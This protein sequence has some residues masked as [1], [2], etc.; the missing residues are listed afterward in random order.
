MVVA[1]PAPALVGILNLPDDSFAGDGLG[2]N[3]DAA[4]SRAEAMLRE[5]A[6]WLDVGAESSR[7]GATAVDEVTERNRVAAICAALVARFDAQV[8]VDTRRAT[9]AEAALAA[10]ARMVNDTSG[11]PT[12]AMAAVV[13]QAGA[14]WVLMHAPHDL[15]DMAPSQASPTMPAGAAAG[16]ARIA[17]DLRRMREEALAAGVAAS[18]L[19][20][21]PGI[22][23]GKDVA[24]N[25]A[26]LLPQPALL[27]L[28]MPLYLGPSRK[29]VLGAVTGRRVE[30]RLPATAVAVAAAVSAG[31][32]YLR[33]HD[34]AAAADAVAM[35][36]ALMEVASE[37][38]LRA[39]AGDG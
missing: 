23:F 9:T 14:A 25:L 30:D 12:S 21:D 32:A 38:E 8:A 29:S 17:D 37:G 22:G 7:P 11:W 39:G 33:V 16:V 31:V 1:R 10:G 18:Q 4:L 5:G 2:A 34:V 13:R 24:Q 36:M 27:G 6:A 28:G 26:L 20:A 3:V 35:A 19:I 15:G